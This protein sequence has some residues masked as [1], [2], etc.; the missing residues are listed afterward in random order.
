[1]S[2]CLATWLPGTDPASKRRACGCR[3]HGGG[4]H[5]RACRLRRVPRCS[6][7]GARDGHTKRSCPLRLLRPN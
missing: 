4:Q 5:Q 7:C 1:M 6:S 2:D 3:G